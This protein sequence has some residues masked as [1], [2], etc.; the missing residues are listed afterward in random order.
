MIRFFRGRGDGRGIGVGGG[1]IL[2]L[3]FVRN[4]NA[5]PCTNVSWKHYSRHIA[6]P[7]LCTGLCCH[8]GLA[9]FEVF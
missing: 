7:M 8:L 3:K 1:G 5:D 6:K 9:F 2:T 4:T